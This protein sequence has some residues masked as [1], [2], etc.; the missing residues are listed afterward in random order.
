M[1]VIKLGPLLLNVELLSFIFSALAG[2][3]VVKYRLRQVHDK[4]SS[5]DK[6]ISAVVIGF[7]VWK[8]SLFLFDPASV[9]QYPM[10]LLYFSGGDKGLVLGI[11]AALVYIWWR[12]RQDSTSLHI[13]IDVLIP[14][15]LAGIGLYQLLQLTLTRT[16]ILFHSL[17]ALFALSAALLWLFKKKVSLAW[18]LQKRN[19]LILLAAILL[20]AWVV[21]DNIEARQAEIE[22]GRQQLTAGEAQVGIKRGNAAPDFEL[23]DLD[24]NPVRLSDYAGKKVV[25]NFWATWCP[26]CRA[27]MPHMEKIY[28]KGED[29]VVLAVN[30]THTEESSGDAQAFAQEYQLSFPVVLDQDGSVSGRYRIVAYPTSYIID[31][32]GI[33]R[34]IYQGAIND[35]TMSKALSRIN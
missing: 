31:S 10:S 23:T 6:Y 33:I 20:A 4:E 22:A 3:L 7:V 28:K 9:I 8:L 35:E 21:Y 24:G 27:E 30:L 26:P 18:F 15:L 19:G 5:S 13:N 32:Q 17:I 2:Y 1:N 16:A 34:D 29:T 12:S 25:L 14:G 11:A